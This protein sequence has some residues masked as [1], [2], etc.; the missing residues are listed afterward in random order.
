MGGFRLPALTVRGVVC[1]AAG[2]LVLE[3]VQALAALLP[4]IVYQ[5]TTVEL[6]HSP[7]DLAT[8]AAA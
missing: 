6:V 8:A 1:G 4:Q 7:A 2:R 3:A 5:A